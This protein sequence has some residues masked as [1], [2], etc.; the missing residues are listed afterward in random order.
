MKSVLLFD[1]DGTLL[2]SLADITLCGNQALELS[3]LPTRTQEE[4]KTY[5]GN[6]ARLLVRRMLDPGDRTAHE[7]QV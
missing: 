5:I 2:D 6:G 7:D 3:G 1:L 4:Y